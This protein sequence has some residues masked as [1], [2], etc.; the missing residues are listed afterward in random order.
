[1]KKFGLPFIILLMSILY[2]FFIPSD[3][4]E[5]RLLFK[6]IPMWLMIGYAC[7]QL[8]SYRT[9]THYLILAGLF[10]CMLGDG[11]LIWFVVGLSAFLIGHLFYMTG[12]FSQWRFSVIRFISII[13][14]GV[15]AFIMA[16]QLINALQTS[17]QDTLILPVL[18]YIAVI[19]LMLWSAIMTGKLQAIMGSILFVVSDSILSW[20]MFISDIL[21]SDMLIMT[22]YYSA[23]FLIA[24][25]LASFQGSRRNSS[26][27]HFPF[28]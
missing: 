15:Y 22:T 20:N 27:K 17:S 6:I 11:L 19:S 8:P 21:Y 26:P 9:R 18:A 3:P 24:R 16:K 2:I 28:N 4:A 7:L 25:S 12:F 5:I 10:F 23:Q 1:M 13:P 14:I